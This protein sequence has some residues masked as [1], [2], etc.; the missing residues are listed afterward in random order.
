MLDE[1]EEFFRNLTS[2]ESHVCSHCG[3]KYNY[4]PYPLF[5]YIC[6]FCKEGTIVHTFRWWAMQFF[7]GVLL[8]VLWG[9]VFYFALYLPGKTPTR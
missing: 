6:P 7:K 1:I 8:V 9:L 3:V 2:Y 5:G 4:N